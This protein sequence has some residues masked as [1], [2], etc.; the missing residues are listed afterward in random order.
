MDTRVLLLGG[1]GFIGQH[2]AQLQHLRAQGLAA[3]EGQQL[4]HKPGRAIGILLDLH[5]VGERRVCRAMARQEPELF[6]C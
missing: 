2:V 4:A 6:F 5:D 3:R 1:S